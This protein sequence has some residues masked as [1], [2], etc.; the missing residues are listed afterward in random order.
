MANL[1]PG[2]DMHTFTT[3][4][5]RRKTLKGYA[6]ANRKQPTPAEQARWLALRNHQVERFRGQ[7]TACCCSNVSASPPG[8]LSEKEMRIKHFAGEPTARAG[9]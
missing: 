4:P 9:V 3:D 1:G 8:P 5:T 7:C 6:R 2:T